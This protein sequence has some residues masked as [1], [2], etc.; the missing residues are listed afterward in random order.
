MINS[1]HYRRIHDC[2]LCNICLN[3]ILEEIVRPQCTGCSLT[4]SMINKSVRCSM[5]KSFRIQKAKSHA[6]FTKV[7]CL[8]PKKIY[9]KLENIP[10]NSKNNFS[11]SVSARIC[12]C[13]SFLFIDHFFFGS[14]VF[15]MCAFAAIQKIIKL[16]LKQNAYIFFHTQIL[17][18]FF[19]CLDF[20]GVFQ[21][22]H[23]WIGYNFTKLIPLIRTE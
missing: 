13:G 5:I 10:M 15:F 23:F 11:D 9:S 18:L 2:A 3:K 1:S 20:L 16:F 21:L 7:L 22:N 17:L 12:V 14:A 19:F 6:I 4:Y 8:G